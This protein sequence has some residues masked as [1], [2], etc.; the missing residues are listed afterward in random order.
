MLIFVKKLKLLNK[1]E[2]FFKELKANKKMITG[3]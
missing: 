3:K 1:I 2:I